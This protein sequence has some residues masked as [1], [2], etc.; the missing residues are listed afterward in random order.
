MG[1]GCTPRAFPPMK[2]TNWEEGLPGKTEV[3]YPDLWQGEALNM[4]ESNGPKLQAMAN[5]THGRKGNAVGM[6]IKSRASTFPWRR[7]GLPSQEKAGLPANRRRC[8]VSAEPLCAPH[9]SHRSSKVVGP[10]AASAR[11]HILPGKDE[12]PGAAF[13]VLRQVTTPAD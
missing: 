3:T 2:K 10:S 9:E 12:P 1:S 6:G 5:H 11:D 8:S 13:T 4:P 7:W